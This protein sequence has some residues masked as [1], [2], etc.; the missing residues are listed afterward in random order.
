MVD[1]VL[2]GYAA[3]VPRYTSYPTATQFSE[4]VNVDTYRAWLGELAPDLDLSLYFHVPFCAALCWF[5]GCQTSVVNRTEPV[6]AYADLLLAEL[7][8]VRS[9]IQGPRRVTH[10]HWGGGTPTIMEP[11]DLLRLMERVRRE[12]SVAPDAEVAIEVDPRV[13][14][15][16][17]A[18][19][20][21]DLGFTRASLGVQ[22]IDPTV[23]RAVNRVQP[24][25]TTIAAAAML[26][27]QGVQALS[28]DL[29]VGLPHQ[30]TQGVRRTVDAVLAAV[31]PTRVSVFAY[32]H[33][34]WLKRHQLRI[35]ESALPD[36]ASRLAQARATADALTGAGF[37]AVGL[38]HFA[39]PDDPLAR[40]VKAGHL[41]RNFQGYTTD[42]AGALIGM[43]ASAI[44]A[45]PQGYAQN[46]RDVPGYRHALNTGSLAA[47]R[48][49]AVSTADR[50]RH[51]IIEKLM[52]LLSVDIDDVATRWG[53]APYEFDAELASLA[54]M[55][56]RGLIDVEGRRVRVREPGRFVVRTVCAAFDQYLGAPKGGRHAPGI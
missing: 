27:E 18:K 29:M 16:A 39:R 20:L 28:V 44:S 36:S 1:D 54:P 50:V 32:A 52:C 35:D 38:D 31:A 42:G 45:L 24:L 25:T 13:L 14:T 3:P 26:R 7:T 51:E 11:A 40:A 19:T 21:G 23:Q 34:P 30:T 41:H 22:D 43:G 5:C 33:V 6:A 2:L 46:H 9:A 10:V 8:R 56:D 55:R 15:A 47:I 17:M 48:G 49:I 12:F 37:V 4:A 53:L